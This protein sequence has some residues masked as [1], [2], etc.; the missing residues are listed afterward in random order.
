MKRSTIKSLLLICLILDLALIGVVVYDYFENNSDWIVAVLAVFAVFVLIT[1]V[2]FALS[3]SKRD[4]DTV[5]VR[6]VV[7][8]GEP[9]TV[10]FDTVNPLVTPPIPPAPL[11]ARAILVPRAQRPVALARKAAPVSDGPFRFNGYTL[12]TRS[13]ELANAGGKR[14]IYFFSKKKPKSGHPCAKP[15]GYHVGVNKRTGLPFLK[16]GAGPDGEDLTPVAAEPDYKP[17]CSAL[18]ADGAQCRNSARGTS[19]YCGSHVGYQPKTVKGA[20]K[21]IEGKRWNPFDKLTNKA[22]VAKADV[23]PKVRGAKDTKPSLRKSLLGR[24]RRSPA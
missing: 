11:H 2:L 19:K 14:S 17:Q 20:A 8:E 5:I 9:A 4:R 12:H 18:T 15:A 21:K 23:K 24:F 7:R 13:V 10:R 1:A 22:S 3:G 16:R 6:E